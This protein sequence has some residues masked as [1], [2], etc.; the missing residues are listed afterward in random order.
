[1]SEA[2]YQDA[3]M[4]HARAPRRAGA[5]EAPRRRVTLDNPLCGDRVTVDLRLADGRIADI[6]QT[7]RGCA[8]CKASASVLAAHAIGT[9]ADG[10]A[11]LHR[12]VGAMLRDAAPPPGAGFD[13]Y[14]IFEPAR[15]AR[16]RHDC[17]LLPIRAA[18]Q[19]WSAE[20]GA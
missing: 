8:L 4:G 12:E 7:V 16:S 10:L 14:V 2:L 11:A 3:I 9:D 19:A 17:I 1:M 6:A 20:E 13:E 15:Q 18:Q 5:L